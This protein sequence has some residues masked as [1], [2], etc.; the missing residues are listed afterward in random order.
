MLEVEAASA[1]VAQR[2][3]FTREAQF[4]QPSY[5]IRHPSEEQDSLL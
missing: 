1:N 4:I 3:S 5:D 2:R